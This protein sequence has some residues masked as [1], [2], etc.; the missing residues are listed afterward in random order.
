MAIA[1]RLPELPDWRVSFQSRVGRLKW[2]GPATDEEIRRAGAEGKGVV[3]AP[4]A[5]V[6][7]HVETLVELDREYAELAR[8]EGCAPYLRTRTP[9]VRPVF[10]ETLAQAALKALERGEGPAPYGPWRCPAGH[11]RCALRSGKAA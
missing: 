6:S 8:R 1:F 10:I 7:E 3:I 9:G 5:F 4:I 2:L 11:G